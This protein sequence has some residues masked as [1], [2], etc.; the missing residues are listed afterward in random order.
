MTPISHWLN[1]AA[2]SFRIRLD[3]SVLSHRV[4]HEPNRCGIDF[5]LIRP[6]NAHGGYPSG[7]YHRL[8][9]DRCVIPPK[10]QSPPQYQARLKPC[11]RFVRLWKFRPSN[12]RTTP[13]LCLHGDHKCVCWISFCPR[14]ISRNFLRWKTVAGTRLLPLL[15]LK[16]RLDAWCG[17]SQRVRCNCL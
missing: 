2:L 8:R 17:K 5:P 3:L 14:V 7:Q 12:A 1:R 4:L 6:P 10:W 15:R 13:L 11:F 9:H 16:A